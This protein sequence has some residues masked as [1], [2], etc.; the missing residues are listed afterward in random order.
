ML[1]KPVAIQWSG[2]FS[3]RHIACW[4]L[5]GVPYSLTPSHRS[6]AQVHGILQCYHKLIK[7]CLRSM[8]RERERERER[9]NHRWGEEKI[10]W[11]FHLCQNAKNLSSKQTWIPVQTGGIFYC[12]TAFLFFRLK[13]IKKEGRRLLCLVMWSHL[14]IMREFC[15]EEYTQWAALSKVF[16]KFIYHR[17]AFS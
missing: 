11:C 9:E 13:Q 15:S 14:V 8:Q 4:S 3:V 1:P 10:L 12:I 17:L 7:Y 16:R 2:N 6:S 5:E